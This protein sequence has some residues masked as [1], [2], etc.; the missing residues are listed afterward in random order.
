MRAKISK[1]AEVGIE[2][3]LAKDQR[4]VIL[5][6]GIDQ[7]QHRN[8]VRDQENDAHRREVEQLDH[9]RIRT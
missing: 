9:L 4:P 3:D 7:S 5:G 2:E 8:A 1:H 6:V